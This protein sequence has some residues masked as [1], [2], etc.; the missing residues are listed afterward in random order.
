MDCV[1]LNG[2]VGVG[3][4]T[5]AD[6]ISALEPGPHAVVDL[7]Q[8]R[9]LHAAP[10]TDAFNHELELRNLRALAANYR[11][12]GA[13]RFI[14]AGVIEEPAE[15]PRYVEALAA[16]GMLVCRLVAESAVVER[17]L[18]SRH[19]DDPDGLEW[20]LHRAGELA[21]ILEAAAL[22][23]VVVDTTEATPQQVARRAREAAGWDDPP[24]R[25]GE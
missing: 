1:F 24:R 12:A 5:V 11:E 9:R 14:L 21:G 2:T 22:D 23:D 25:G 13:R 6:A 18:R 10:T 3:K 4:S 8:V 7:D 15:V 16:D 19:A 20:H 17:R